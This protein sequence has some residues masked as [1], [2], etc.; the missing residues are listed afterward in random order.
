MSKDNMKYIELVD[1]VINKLKNE[2]D[3]KSVE[4]KFKA[5]V[6][7]LTESKVGGMPFIPAGGA[8]PVD[9]K[10]G[11]KLYLLIQINFAEVPHLPDYPESG[12]LQIFIPDDDMYGMDCMV[13]QVQEA[14][15]ILYFEDIS[16]PMSEEE[17]KNLMP[18]FDEDFMLPFEKPGTTCAIEFEEHL[19]PISTGDYKFDKLFQE[20][21]GEELP[22]NELMGECWKYPKE[23]SK[24]IY[25][26]CDGFGSRLGGYPGF[27]QY[28]P[29]DEDSNEILLLQIDSFDVDGEWFLMWGDAGIAN[30][31]IKPEDLKNRNFTRVNYN[32]DCS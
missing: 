29:R 23:F 22:A 30:F 5:G 7:G 26:A 1:T 13:G 11:K 28:D 2:T 19:M 12:I 25:E 10:N 32:W 9:K 8:Y 24:K 3:K 21:M 4:M 31:F 15:R 27:T 17:I 6:P 16:N 20:I 14:W 18:E